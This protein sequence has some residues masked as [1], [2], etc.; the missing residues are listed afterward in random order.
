MQL[1]DYI[2]TDRVKIGLSVEDWRDLVDH[3]GAIMLD[4]GD[5]QARYIEAMKRVTEEMGPYSV[6]APGVVLLH[7]RPEDG[8]NRICFAIATLKDE[9]KFGSVN[10]P[11]RLAIGMGALDHT[12][13]L[14]ALRG[15]AELL[16]DKEKVAELIKSETEHELVSIL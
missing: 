14:E 8:V 6:I 7:A 5:I 3:V 1:I 4:A 12:S 11:V 15:M 10:D 2:T 16:G 13:H 9:I